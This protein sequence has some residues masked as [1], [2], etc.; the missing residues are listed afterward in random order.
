[1][2]NF[3][4]NIIKK[5]LW[6][7]LFLFMFLFTL[8]AVFPNTSAEDMIINSSPVADAGGPYFGYES[9]GVNFDASGSYDPDGDSLLYRWN[10]H[11]DEWTEW[12]SN[13][14]EIAAWDDDF[15]GTIVLEVTDEE[16]YDTSTAEVTIYNVDPAIE[17]F[18]GEYIF[19]EVNSE[20]EIGA[21]FWDPD[22]RAF[23]NDTYSAVFDWNDG[24]S[25]T[26]DVEPEI[27][28][29]SSAHIFTEIGFY[30]FSLQII[31]DDGGIGE[32]SCEIIVAGVDV[33]ENAFLNEGD[34]F[35]QTGSFLIVEN[36][37]E[38]GHV[39]YDDGNGFISLDLIE[40][41]SS[42]ELAKTYLDN[43]IFDVS[44]IITD[45]YGFEIGFDNI[46]IEVANVAPVIQS[47]YN[48]PSDPIPVN[49]N[50]NL[51]ADFIDPG[52]LDTHTAEIN[53]GDGVITLGDIDGN[54]ISA[55]HHY[56]EAGVYTISITVTDDDG[57]S[58]SAFYQYVVVFDPDEGFVTGGGVINSPAGAYAPDPGLEGKATFGFVSKYK[59]GQ[60]TP[61]GNTEFQFHAAGLNFHSKDYDWLI[62]AGSKAM[63]KGTGTINGEGNYGF[64]LSAI[65]GE[66]KGDGFDKFRIKIW[67]KDTSD[68]IY[69][70]NIDEDE[71]GNPSTVLDSGQI[72][73][74][75][76]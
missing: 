32:A 5:K 6:T 49:E 42:F 41:D 46:L 76:K 20:V 9:F 34:T 38:A 25:V 24:T 14:Y 7:I 8:V 43:G 37:V 65:D 63:Y 13:P 54:T 45:P 18:E 48:L 29:V 55:S 28:T 11:E 23:C 26:F 73:I 72:K 50:V 47:I 67:N 1:M 60:S 12:S 61:S 75:K 64:M 68:I 74:H 10:Y 58:T 69:D 2:K 30:D 66:I 40:E 4:K 51:L 57:D 16:N 35:L 27:F 52:L 44:V 31:D 53:W 59:K 19:A 36:E 70:N 3:E 21:Y 22:P 15:V 71:Y 39:D 33:G 62:I 17:L 56:L